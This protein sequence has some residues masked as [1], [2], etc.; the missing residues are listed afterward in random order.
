MLY[1]NN[2][3]VTKTDDLTLNTE[4]C[5]PTYRLWTEMETAV[6]E[7]QPEPEWL[8]E[9]K[10]KTEHDQNQE[11]PQKNKLKSTILTDLKDQAQEKWNWLGHISHWRHL[12]CESR[13][14]GQQQN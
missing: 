12:L 5:T 6:E 13:M 8:K 14:D 1:G 10:H 7:D 9:R 4:I 11:I 2:K 3:G